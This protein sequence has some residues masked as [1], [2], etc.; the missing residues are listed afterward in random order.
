MSLRFALFATLALAAC[1]APRTPPPVT[2][3][4]ATVAERVQTRAPAAT[5][6]NLAARKQLAFSD[7]AAS[8]RNVTV[9]ARLVRVR[10]ET[11]HC[12]GV[13]FGTQMEYELVSIEAG[14]LAVGNGLLVGVGCPDI[15]RERYDTNAGTLV[16]FRVG[17]VHRLTLSNDRSDSRGMAVLETEPLFYAISADPAG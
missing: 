14:T 13:H 17:E 16:A 8:S 7:P 2:T 5:Q 3:A 11:P 6:A 1:P 10:Q 9:T 15:P 4:R 12:G